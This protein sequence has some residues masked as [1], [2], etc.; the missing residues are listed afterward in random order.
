[1]L[2]NKYSTSNLSDLRFN[3]EILEE[4]S[5][6]AMH[7]DIPHIIISGPKGGGKK[8]LVKFLLEAIYNDDVN[9]LTKHKY[10][11]NGSSAKTEI[12]ILQSDY[13]IIVEPAGTNHD[14]YILQEIIKQYA[15]QKDFTFFTKNSRKFKTILIYNIENLSINSQAALRRTMEMYAKTCRFIMICNNLSK[16]FDPLR[17]R[18]RIFCV[19][20]PSS[21]NIIDIQENVLH[22]ENIQ[23]EEDQKEYI[24]NNAESNVKKIIWIDDMI[25]LEMNPKLPLEKSFDKVVELI[26][27]CSKYKSVDIPTLRKFYSHIS[28]SE[29][30]ILLSKIKG[31]NTSPPKFLNIFYS[32][33]RNEAYNLIITNIKGSD[34]IAQ[35]LM[36]FIEKIS[37]QDICH[38]ITK[39]ASD[40]EYNM[41]HGRRDI[42]HIDYFLINVAKEL[43]KCSQKKITTSRKTTKKNIKK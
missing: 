17:S 21:N 22:N 36:M 30:K 33:I 34:I 23:L 27:I 15:S 24:K 4:L 32:E 37:D 16:I 1:M 26:L 12:E 42:M 14:K 40:A 38:K 2:L 35:L 19:P 28:D 43:Y 39:H 8:T 11:I 10:N 5:F 25:K 31:N 9:I 13:H 20:L 18:C 6:I 29:F 41:I 7:D 3:Q